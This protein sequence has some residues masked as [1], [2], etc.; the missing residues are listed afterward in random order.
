MDTIVEEHPMRQPSRTAFRAILA[1]LLVCS[2]L[3]AAMR[4]GSGAASDRWSDPANWDGSVPAA[5][6][7]LVFPHLSTG[8]AGSTNDLASGTMFHSITVN[9]AGYR[10]GGNAIALGGGG[11]ILNAPFIVS[12]IHGELNFASITLTESQTWGGLGSEF[13]RL[14]LTNINGKTLTIANSVRLEFGSITGAGAIIDNKS[15]FGFLRIESSSYLGTV[16]V[17][18]GPFEITGTAGDVEVNSSNASLE[19]SAGNIANMTVNGSGALSLHG[20]SG[21]SYAA[22]NLAFPPATGYP[23]SFVIAD[24][25]IPVA[26]N[27]TGRVSLGNA[28]LV[29]RPSHF[30]PFTLIHN[31]GVDPVGGTFLGLPEG[32]VFNNG[33]WVSISYVGGS[34]HDVTLTPV[35]T[36]VTS[37]TTTITASILPASPG[38]I[39]SFT[40]AVTSALGTPAGVVSFY[41]GGILLGTSTLSPSGHAILTTSFAQGPHLVTAAYLGSETFAISQASVRPDICDPPVL[42]QQ[43]ASQSI[44]QGQVITLAVQGSGTA[45]FSYQWYEGSSGDFSKPILGAISQAFRLD[46]LTRTTSFWVQVSNICGAVQSATAT[47]TVGPPRRRTV[48]H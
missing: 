46:A 7:D 40:A 4:T 48:R 43:P 42:T 2:P 45:P 18:S 14:G 22:G 32:A 1:F 30:V 10:V 15:A 28:L 21:T 3:S 39:V 19:L 36:P 20:N 26:C 11:L 34:G 29:V 13:T 8:R 47:I 9:A 33:S 31:Q 27:V 38:E 44:V 5:G 17:N 23:A 35:S 37:T 16:T 12:L 6:D 41:D 24:G 25:A